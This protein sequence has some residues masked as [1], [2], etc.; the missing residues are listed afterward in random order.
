MK[1]NFQFRCLVGVNSVRREMPKERTAEAFVTGRWDEKPHWLTPPK[2]GQVA[3]DFANASDIR[4]F[5]EGYGPLDD[6]RW[7]FSS[8]GSALLIG[9]SDLQPFK[10]AESGWRDRQNEFKVIAEYL[11]MKRSADHVWISG[12]HDVVITRKSFELPV[13]GAFWFVA[14]RLVFNAASLWEFL[15]LDLLS[16]GR[17]KLRRCECP[18]CETPYF[19]GKSNA[20]FCETPSCKR[21]G[22]NQ[23][24]LNWWNENRRAVKGTHGTKGRGS[25]GTQKT[26]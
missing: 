16:V 18:D 23:T 3:M 24:K 5:T 12:F 8:K 2:P 11:F 6:S 26:R 17:D 1:A 13:R 25:D 14:E 15:L 20:R 10:F 21:W 9:R 19:V 22:R 4:R 7:E